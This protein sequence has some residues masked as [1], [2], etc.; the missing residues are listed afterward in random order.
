MDLVELCTELVHDKFVLR[1]QHGLGDPKLLLHIFHSCWVSTSH[2]QDQVNNFL[3]LQAFPAILADVFIEDTQHVDQRDNV[4]SNSLEDFGYLGL[5]KHLLELELIHC[6]FCAV[7]E[8]LHLLP[9]LRGQKRN[10][11]AFFLRG[12]N[13]SNNINEHADKH[14]HDGQRSQQDKEHDERPEVPTVTSH[15]Q[16][17]LRMVRQNAIQQQ[18]VHAMVDRGEILWSDRMVYAKLS[19]KQREDVYDEHPKRKE[20]DDRSGGKSNAFDDDHKFWNGSKNLCHT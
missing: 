17:Y 19:E 9:H 5:P 16:D 8:E 15:V 13:D 10:C 12:S 6:P 11:H 14:V 4:D 1:I 18:G 3:E 2:V 20:N 7:V